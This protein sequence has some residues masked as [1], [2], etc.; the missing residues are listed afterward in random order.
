MESKEALDK[1]LFTKGRVWTVYST[2][3]DGSIFCFQGIKPH[4]SFK[5]DDRNNYRN[6]PIAYFNLADIEDKFIQK[7]EIDFFI[8]IMET[9][10][11]K[12]LTK[13]KAIDFFVHL[14]GHSRAFI[15]KRTL[16]KGISGRGTY[17]FI[18]GAIRY[19]LYKTEGSLCL[20]HNMDGYTHHLYYDF[21]TFYPHD[22]LNEKR[23]KAIK[24]EII[25]DY[26]D[27]KGIE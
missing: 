14:T 1:V 21:I 19:E 10:E 16:E 3:E 6:L 15:S 26:K 23:N 17:E 8:K 11:K 24:E 27:W 5:F 7:E 12:P 9:E 22:Y 4:E 18:P 13:K 25:N 20:R 2:S